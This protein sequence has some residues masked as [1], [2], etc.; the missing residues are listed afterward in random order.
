VGTAS[1]PRLTAVI[2]EIRFAKSG[3]VHIAYQVLGDG[4]VDLVYIPDWLSNLELQWEEPACA[5]FLE[6]LASCSRLLLFDKRGSGLSDRTVDSD[7]FTLEIRVDD[8][9]AVMDAAHSERAF[10]F[11]AGDDGGA[12][13]AVFAATHPDRTIGLILYGSRA[14]GIKTDDYPF[15]YDLS[16]PDVWANETESFWASEAYGRRWLRSLAPSV[17]QDDRTVRWYARLLRQSSSP[18]TEQAFERA[19][20]SLDLRG[21]LSAI[22]APTLVLHRVGDTDV[23]VEGGRDLADRIGGARFVELPGIDPFPWSGQPEPLLDEIEAFVS[24][25]KPSD[26]EDR[27]LST[28][29]F[30]D[31]VGSTEKLAELGDAAWR[32]LISEHDVLVRRALELHR[33]MEVDRTGDGFLATFDGPARAVRCA[34]EVA[35]QVR[36]LGI[37]IRAG[38]HTGEIELLDG[39][40]R[41]I[42]VH[43]GARVMGL[44][45]PSEVLVSSTVKELVGGSGL[46]FEDR[47]IHD[48]KGVP[49][50]WQVFAATAS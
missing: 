18:G 25:S 42:A 28:V 32:E 7:L 35:D 30:T 5:G 6:R 13:A 50:R 39:E 10:V 23:P 44:A 45:G 12:I 40:V 37:E 9:R 2:P 14:K 19:T 38:C 11:G 15:G 1:G 31:I 17:A 4:P 20:I 34:R 49:G 22:H 27:V 8:V 48:L 43:I 3:D 29:L 16:A 47:G 41:G 26:T 33:G 21:I 46:S 36:R 24:G